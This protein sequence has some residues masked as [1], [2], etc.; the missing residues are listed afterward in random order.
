METNPIEK[1]I[2]GSGVEGGENE[3]EKDPRTG[4]YIED[5]HTV[6]TLEEKDEEM[7]NKNADPNWFREQK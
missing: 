4:L 7:K 1:K 6:K 3:K 5:D 2:A